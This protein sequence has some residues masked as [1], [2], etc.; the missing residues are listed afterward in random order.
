MAQV[1]KRCREE[2][3]SDGVY[4]YYAADMADPQSATELIKVC[5]CVRQNAE[6]DTVNIQCNCFKLAAKIITL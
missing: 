4:L 5:M 2:G 1:V 3:S 6:L